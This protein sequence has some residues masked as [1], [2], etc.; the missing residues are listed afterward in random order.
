VGIAAMRAGM[1]A[2]R[3]GVP[4][5]CRRLGWKPK[6]HQAANSTAATP[7]LSSGQ[8]ACHDDYVAMMEQ[9]GMTLST[10]APRCERTPRSQPLKDGAPARQPH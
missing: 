7:S 8:R 9:M 5:A 10:I 2:L 4:A 1:V 3:K 6:F